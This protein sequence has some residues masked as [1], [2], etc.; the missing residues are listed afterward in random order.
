MTLEMHGAREDTE[1]PRLREQGNRVC[2]VIKKLFVAQCTHTPEDIKDPR[3]ALCCKAM[4]TASTAFVRPV[5][6]IC[7]KIF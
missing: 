2:Y 6:L 1:V 5:S 4:A 3:G 7:P